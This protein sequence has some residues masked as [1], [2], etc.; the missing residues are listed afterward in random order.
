MFFF[1]FFFFFN[2]PFA[3]FC[4]SSLPTLSLFGSCSTLV[5]LFVLSFEISPHFLSLILFL[6]LFLLHFVFQFLF[7]CL[8]L[9]C[10]MI[11]DFLVAQFHLRVGLGWI[12]SHCIGLEFFCGILPNCARLAAVAKFQ[13][14]LQCHGLL[15]ITGG[16]LS[17]PLQRQPLSVCPV[18]PCSFPLVSRSMTSCSLF[19][20]SLTI[21]CIFLVFFLYRY[22]FLC[23]PFLFLISGQTEIPEGV[24]C[25]I[26]KLDA[27][28]QSTAMPQL[29]T[30]GFIAICSRFPINNYVQALLYGQV[31]LGG[32]IR[33]LCSDSSVQI[34]LF[35]QLLA[36]CV[37]PGLL[38]FLK[39]MPH[40]APVIIPTTQAW[41]Q[42]F[43]QRAIDNRHGTLNTQLMRTIPPLSS[44]QWWLF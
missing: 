35:R 29:G 20:P 5:R 7:L 8:F 33:W 21:F 24:Q 11:S 38:N 3:R 39:Y 18:L 2:C 19:P 26:V 14:L 42:L 37:L 27:Y 30:L 31:L 34:A 9:L 23:S 44:N 1:F 4:R 32:S 28:A 15:L 16:L 10:P 41:L 25:S 6:L 36:A 12:G 17:S 22:R 13:L 43:A 40:I